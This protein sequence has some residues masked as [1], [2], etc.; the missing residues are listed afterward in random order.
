M[1]SGTGIGIKIGKRIGLNSGIGIEVENDSKIGSGIGTNSGIG[2]EVENDSKIGSGIG[3]NSGIE[4]EN[5]SRFDEENYFATTSN[6]NTSFKKRKH[7]NKPEKDKFI[8]TEQYFVKDRDSSEIFGKYIGMQLQTIRADQRIIAEKL[9]SD[10]LYLA[11]NNKLS[12]STTVL[13]HSLIE[14]DDRKG[15]DI[16]LL[17]T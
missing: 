5:S 2:I 4:I 12:E 17:P 16:K 9:M 8:T 10:V 7:E 14:N 11:R 6:Q 13:A 15:R 3:T 1:E